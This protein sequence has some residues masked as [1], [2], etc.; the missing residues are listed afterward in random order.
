MI[1]SDPMTPRFLQVAKVRRE[2]DDTCTVLLN[3]TDQRTAFLPGQFNM[4]YLHGLGEVPISIS[5][6]PED[7]TRIVHTT[8]AVGVV[9]SAIAAVHAGDWMG[10]RGPFG[11][12]WPVQQA[13]GNDVVLI[14]GG[15]G[16]A[17][18]RPALYSILS[19]RNQYG[20][21]ALLYGAR[22]PED[23]L[24]RKEL[25]SWRARFDLE[26]AVTVEHAG[27]NW[28][29]HVGFVTNLIP[30]AAFDP[31]NTIAMICGPEVMMRFTALELI[32]RGMDVTDIFVSIER[33]MKCGVGLCGH[34]QM[35]PKFVCKDGPVF[36]FNDVSHW[37]AKG[38]I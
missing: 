19:A 5:G 28:R 37:L 15:I 32:K 7:S 20:K 31:A 13:A 33:N 8:R 6:N 12:P 4:L 3:E 23:L 25:E 18:L 14:A 35:G 16:M 36:C 9:S 22:S 26:V 21:V 27:A 24:F 30:R 34:C 10:I 17:P 38:E 29:G 11:A 1:L 2:T